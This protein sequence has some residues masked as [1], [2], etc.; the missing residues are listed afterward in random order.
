MILLLLSLLMA[1]LL[2][3]SS[4]NKANKHKPWI[5][6][7]YQGI[8]MEND[9]TVL[10]NPPLFALDKDAP[11]R[12][13]GEICGFRLHGS[14]VP[15][16]AV[17]LDKATGEGLIR[18]KE[19]VDCEAQKEHTFTI[20]AYDCGEGPDGTNTKKSHKATVHVRVNDV[21]EFAP[22]FV[23]R[24][25]RAAVTEGKLYDRI[26]RVE[27]IDGDC[28]P[29]YSQICYYEILT[30][31][32]PFLIDNDGNIE[33]TEKLQYSGE[34]LYKF[35]V[36]AY[37]CGKKRAADD[38]EVEIQVKP[39]C[40]PSWQ[41]WN[42]RI[43]YAPGAGSLALF[44]GIRLETCDEP[45]WNIQA[46]IELQT[47]HVAKGCDRDN[48]SE[49][50]LRKLC[51]AATGE[52][53]LLP[54]PGPNANWT[55]GLSV[56]YSQDSSLIYWFNGTQAVQVP[57]GGPAGLG[58]GP[59]DGLSDH[60]TLSFWMKHGVTP[61]KGKKEEE[62]I[63]C[64]TVQNEDGFSHYSLTVHGCRIAFLYWPLLESARP[65]KFLWKL[66]QVC[67]DEWHHYA[68]NL[69]F[70][71]VTLYTDGISFD[72]ALIHD[73][74]LIHPPRREP[75]LMI[76]ACW[77]EEKNK[78]KEKGDNSTDTTPGDPLLIHHYFH[79][80]LAGFSVRSG[81]L[82]SREVIECLYACREG[83]DYRD[84]ESLGKGMKVHVNP[85][86]SL[87]TLEGDDVETFNHALQHV[88]YMNTLRFATPGVRP[89]R[90][91]T[92]VKCFSE[93]S[94]VSIP[95]VEGY[96]V[97]LQ[98]DAPQILLSGTAHFARP[99]V[100]FEGPEGVPLFPDLQIT[101]SIS[102]QVEAK[103][104]ESW[105][106]TVTDTRMSDEIVHNLDGCEISLVGD[107]LDPERESLLLDMASLQ[108]R[109]LELTNTSA[110]L[111]IAG[112]ETITVYEEILRHARYQLR[113]GAA[114]YARKFRLSCSEM[115]GRYSSNEFIVEVNVLHS[116]NR[117]AHPSHVLS[118]QQFL[119]RG[120]QPP[121]E[122]AGHSLASSHRNSMVPSAATLIIVVC[123]GF[124]VLMV[125]LGLVRIHSLHRRVSGTGGPSGAS[126]D[127]KDPDLFWDDSALTI[128]VNPM[129]SYQNQQAGVAG[130][131]GGQQEEEDSSD[132]EAAD[133][134]SSDERRIIESPPHRY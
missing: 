125:I 64:N 70:P 30:P 111:T 47:S 103:A 89:L 100:D 11:L 4:G 80:Y 45:L 122:M 17:I 114:L 25:Y 75:A 128:I 51:G 49:R 40:K 15:F 86:Q 117:V 10:L 67:D 61:S 130:V 124:L 87:L 65:V 58:S 84:F 60:F 107:D 46:T 44:P 94:C 5:E 110:Y 8:V 74:G 53:D 16:E 73:N 52:V 7:E 96:V 42:K 56:H 93:E 43:E 92:A 126:T 112:V 57:L 62:T 90:L 66:E 98:P 18:A 82:E 32:T 9:N 109:G 21:N 3:L 55:A 37:D 113:H 121:P 78:E 106:G 63:V 91:T 97:V 81:R 31:N 36:T 12:Y 72:P 39:T 95:E 19:P 134:P 6:A 41:G 120:H 54:M 22:V 76:G 29:Q 27:A 71:T 26:L 69:E 28:S 33:N 77:T 133:S 48:Y 119:H 50:A 38:A 35:T 131:A 13:A 108:Q 132:S 129:E 116:M 85:S 101:C 115:N 102:H 79:G 99:A 1:S 118:S 23:E 104:D 88:A 83:L 59:Q 68:L 2:Q 14:G 24:L 105:Q 127:P 20:Q 123:V 34:K